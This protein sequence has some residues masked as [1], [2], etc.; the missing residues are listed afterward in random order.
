MNA[1]EWRQK[2]SVWW[3][4]DVTRLDYGDYGA[5]LWARHMGVRCNACRAVLKPALDS[6]RG[7]LRL[8]LVA[9]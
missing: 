1:W 5:I 6:C 3:F 4:T 7:P 2:A 9:L 8:L